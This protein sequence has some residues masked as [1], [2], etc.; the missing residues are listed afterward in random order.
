MR[1]RI[2]DDF[3]TPLEN[4]NSASVK[5]HDTA[6]AV[7]LGGETPHSGCGVE[8]ARSVLW[9]VSV[10]GAVLSR[11]C[12][13][14]SVGQATRE[15]LGQGWARPHLGGCRVAWLA[16]LSKAPRTEGGLGRLATVL[17]QQ[18]PTSP[19]YGGDLVIISDLIESVITKVEWHTSRDEAEINVE[20]LQNLWPCGSRQVVGGKQVVGGRQM[21]GGRQVVG[22]SRWEAD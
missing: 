9:P 5:S 21:V 14:G 18:L 4:N 3:E 20:I 22:E 2:L 13:T 19:V 10:P 12:P 7:Y 1:A 15:C 11:P 17:R 8:V 6:P 16:D